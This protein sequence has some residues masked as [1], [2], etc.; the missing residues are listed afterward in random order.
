LPHPL[1]VGTIVTDLFRHLDDAAVDNVLS[2]GAKASQG[3]D[4]PSTMTVES[5]AATSLFAAT[6]AALEQH[7]GSPLV[8]CAVSDATAPW[9]T[10]A[11]S[12]RQLWELCDE[13]RTRV[14]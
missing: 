8:A 7:G 3:S 6:S 12:A 10:D 2:R 14:P 5:G 11:A 9:A 1:C 13:N 4:S